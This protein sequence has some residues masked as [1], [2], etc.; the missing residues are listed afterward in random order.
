MAEMH[1]SYPEFNWA[2]N[3]G[4]GTKAHY[5]ALAK[6]GYTPHHRRSFNPLKTKLSQGVA[7]PYLPAYERGKDA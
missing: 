1:L 5:D 6:F 7:K 2:Q 3:A 4:Y